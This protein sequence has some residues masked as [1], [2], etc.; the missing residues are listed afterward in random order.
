MEE[1]PVEPPQLYDGTILEADADGDIVIQP[2]PVAVDDA[3]LC[4]LILHPMLWV[5]IRMIQEMTMEM[6]MKMT[7]TLIKT[8]RRKR[9]IILAT[10]EL[11]TKNTPLRRT[12]SSAFFSVRYCSTWGT[13]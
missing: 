3:P 11:S 9:M 7:T 13:P 8:L 6:R 1:K 12:V 5:V 4:L 2:A 10:V